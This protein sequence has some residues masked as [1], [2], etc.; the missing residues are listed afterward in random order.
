MQSSSMRAGD[1]QLVMAALEHAP[2]LI[3]ILDLEG[4]YV[5]LG[6]PWLEVLG[7]SPEDVVGKRP[8]DL[9][10][11]DD[12]P[13]LA[14]VMQRAYADMSDRRLDIRMMRK[15]GGTRWIAWFGAGTAMDGAL[16]G[17]GIDVTAEREAREAEARA[18]EHLRWVLDTVPDYITEVDAD[19]II[20]FMNRTYPGV[21][22]EQV[23]G[24]NIMNWLASDARERF[25]AAIQRIFA[26][27]GP[28]RLVVVGSGEAGPTMYESRLGP[29]R[30]QAGNVIRVI[31]VGK[32]ITQEYRAVAERSRR[33]RLETLGLMSASVAHDFNNLMTIVGFGAE[34]ATHAAER[35]DLAQVR[36]ALQEI[37]VTTERCV[38]LTKQLHGSGPDSPD[39]GH[40][41]DLCAAIR[42]ARPMMTRVLGPDIETTIDAPSSPLWVPVRR[43]ELYQVLANLASNSRKAIHERGHVR[44]TV[45][46]GN[47]QDPV[48]RNKMRP[49]AVL[50]FEDDGPGIPW[51]IQTHVFDAFFTFGPQGGTGIGLATVYGI[52]QSVGGEVMLRSAAD[53]G[54][55]FTFYLP[56]APGRQPEV[57]A[58]GPQYGGTET[59]LV[60]DD[61]PMIR[62]STAR[63]LSRLGYRALE[64]GDAAEAEAVAK[65]HKGPIHLLLTDLR[66]P[67]VDG[68]ELAE[69]LRKSRPGFE[70][71]VMTGYATEEDVA[72]AGA[73]TM[74][75]KPFALTELARVVRATLDRRAGS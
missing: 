14:E 6:G 66:M 51:E 19:G 37:T 24:T 47:A 67:G 20:T 62:A 52:V 75:R 11:P 10:H 61:E 50:T 39:E 4:R 59:V 34:S 65:A 13:K 45:R 74:L 44:C 60:V 54:T 46:P 64:A 17:I 49:A 71:L 26:G 70:V 53:E 58:P 8:V 48:L 21:T 12:V 22:I 32:D 18:K 56:G 30:D 36:A 68:L 73:A 15:G 40:A 31:L 9:A 33:M 27:G 25:A 3:A 2:V 69:L 28:E 57:A 41:I 7:L 35:G 1:A 72:R 23:V 29:M 43:V 55:T 63:Y 42:E 38:E 16:V 5:Q